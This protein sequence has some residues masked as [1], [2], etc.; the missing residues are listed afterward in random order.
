METSTDIEKPTLSSENITAPFEKVITA[1]ED[2]KIIKQNIAAMIDAMAFNPSLIT[3]AANYWGVRAWWQKIIAGI[4]LVVPLF[5]IGALVP[6]PLVLA[7]SICLLII[8]VSCILL[9]DNHYSSNNSTTSNL[10][11][12]MEG[13]ADSLGKIILSLNGVHKD[14]VAL[15]GFFQ[16]ENERLSSHVDSLCSEVDG[17]RA[18]N[19]QLQ[20]TEAALR[21]T[22]TALEQTATELNQTL[23]EQTQQHHATQ[24]E[25]ERVQHE[26]QANQAEFFAQIEK[27]KTIEKGLRDNIEQQR[28]ISMTLQSALGVFNDT[29]LLDDT[30]KRAF[31]E[32]LTKFIEDKET[33]FL[34]ISGT[35][36]EAATELAQVKSQL[37]NTQ[38]ELQALTERYQQLLER[39][40][41][42]IQ[43]LE[44]IPSPVKVPESN[45]EIL[46]NIGFMAAKNR[47]GN[48]ETAASMSH[49]P[50]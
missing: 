18:Q 39:S 2:L 35:I 7:I 32:K 37:A 47:G 41:K 40:E 20:A 46:A 21:Q 42:Q 33:S 45:S 8:Y 43:R 15:V 12:G 22:Q 5:L 28:T 4:I 31:Q 48:G 19:L 38:Q 3:H 34:L 50:F 36:K 17:L 23:S 13:L 49:R 1:E 29:L 25:L 30:Q 9:L 27:F 14:L 44:G 26:L 10:K 16:K 11:A 24:Q 6:V